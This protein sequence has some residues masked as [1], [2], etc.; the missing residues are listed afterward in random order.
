MDLINYFKSFSFIALSFCYSFAVCV[1]IVEQ[2]AKCCAAVRGPVHDSP[3]SCDF[4]LAALELLAAL[5]DQCPE[6]QDPTHL[7]RIITL[8]HFE[9]IA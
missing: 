8:L 3:T 9:I 1:G 2:L 7:V 4:L 6:E 5:A